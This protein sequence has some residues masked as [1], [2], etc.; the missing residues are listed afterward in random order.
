MKEKEFQAKL[1]ELKVEDGIKIPIHYSLNDDG[2]V[3][4]D[5]QGLEIDFKESLMEIEDLDLN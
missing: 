4:V 1:K 3:F 5:F 2:D